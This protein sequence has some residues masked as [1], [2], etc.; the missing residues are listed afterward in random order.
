M[1]LH[2][3]STGNKL[4]AEASPVHPVWGIG[5]RADDPRAKDPHK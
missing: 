2:L 1:K 5:L 4:L 3:L